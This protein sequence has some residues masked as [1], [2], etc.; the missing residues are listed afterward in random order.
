[1]FS[2]DVNQQKKTMA[3]HAIVLSH[4]LESYEADIV[5]DMVDGET[6]D[7]IKRLPASYNFF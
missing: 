1:M 7:L 3:N 5:T 4:L 6:A 2:I